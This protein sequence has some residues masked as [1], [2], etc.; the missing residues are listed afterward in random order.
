MRYM[1]VLTS[2]QMSVIRRPYDI[3]N[4]HV[5]KVSLQHSK[6]VCVRN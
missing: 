2:T 6:S 3:A 5:A 4:V 1:D